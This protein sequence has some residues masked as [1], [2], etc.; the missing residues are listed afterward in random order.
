MTNLF[1]LFFISQFKRWN[2]SDVKYFYIKLSSWGR[3]QF[4]LKI[5]SFR[6]TLRIKPTCKRNCYVCTKSWSSFQR[7]VHTRTIYLMHTLQSSF[8]YR[9]RDNG[10]KKLCIAW[11]YSRLLRCRK[12]LRSNS[13]GF[14]IKA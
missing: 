3:E 11:I 2:L 10:K 6:T 12:I 1:R 9:A 4:I 13:S 5:Y 7:P 8:I 14:D